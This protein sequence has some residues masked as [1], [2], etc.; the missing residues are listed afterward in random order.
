M[1]DTQPGQY[2]G[3]IKRY[4]VQQISALTTPTSVEQQPE[5]ADLRSRAL[6][7]VSDWSPESSRKPSSFLP[8]QSFL[9]VLGIRQLFGGL[10]Q[11]SRAE[12]VEYLLTNSRLL[13]SVTSAFSSA[14]RD[15]RTLAKV[16]AC[17][18]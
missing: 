13:R 8:R 12:W 11:D 4:V 1:F 16:S 17:G 5:N 3:A 7:E 15:A 18:A 10:R 2:S 6:S 14:L 9:T